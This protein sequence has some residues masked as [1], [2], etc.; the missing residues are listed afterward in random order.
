MI[1]SPLI[2]YY[3]LSIVVITS[4]LV[5]SRK[6]QMITVLYFASL[7]ARLGMHQQKIDSKAETPAALADELT[8]L[9][10]THAAIFFERKPLR[11]AINQR[12]AG[13]DSPIKPGDEVAFFP[14]VT[15]G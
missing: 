15:G 10:D 4:C 2:Q 1:L 13:W 11:V 5:L 8:M 9:S 12:Y 7:R 6:L 3:R 14:P